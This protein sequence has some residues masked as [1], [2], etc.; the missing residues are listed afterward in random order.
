MR[1]E[2]LLKFLRPF[3]G[4]VKNCEYVPVPQHYHTV[5]IPSRGND[6]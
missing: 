6:A 4:G 2:A 5:A 3:P 1:L